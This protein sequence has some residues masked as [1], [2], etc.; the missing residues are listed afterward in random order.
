MCFKS[1]SVTSLIY[2]IEYPWGARYGGV[3]SV[4]GMGVTKPISSVPL[5]SSFSKLSNHWLPIEYHVHICQMSPQLSCGDICQIWMW[6]IGSNMYFHMMVNFYVGEIKERTPFSNSFSVFPQYCSCQISVSE[7][8]QWRESTMLRIN[9]DTS[10]EWIKLVCAIGRN[11]LIQ[12]NFRTRQP[13]AWCTLRVA[14]CYAVEPMFYIY[15]L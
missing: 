12:W 14:A 1:R 13:F 2:S 6:F 4:P 11:I 10:S 3:T 9:G 8:F 15:F 5:F 7:T